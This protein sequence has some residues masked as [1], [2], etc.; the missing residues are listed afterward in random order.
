LQLAVVRGDNLPDGPLVGGPR[1]LQARKD[2]AFIKPRQGRLRVETPRAHERGLY[3]LLLVLPAALTPLVIVLGRHRARLQQDTG[4][5]RARR[6]HDRARKRFEAA[7][8]RL[9]QPD[10]AAF[11]E[12][13]ARTL[14]DYLA[15]RT[16]RAAAGLTYDRADELLAARGIDVE[17]RR[18][19]RACLER[20][21]FVRF[22]P[23]AARVERRSEVLDEAE[24]I[25]AAL[26][27]A[28]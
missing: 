11:H 9:A 20:C 19:Y 28:W 17:L 24:R 21:D 7:R 4:R 6:A 23:E 12:E 27:Q 1:E 15:D 3:R 13:V 8:K 5:T 2:L 22:V 10:T 16:N 14:V 25:V 26:E 18:R